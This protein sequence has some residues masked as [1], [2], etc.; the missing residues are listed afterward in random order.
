MTN[1][2]FYFSGTGNSLKVAKSIAEELKNVEIVSMNQIAEVN[3]EKEYETIGFV[4]PVYFGG[5][6]NKVYDFVSNLDL[7]N[8]KN[9]YYYGIATYGGFVGN[10]ISQLN[11]LLQYKH[12]LSLDFGE[13]LKMFA[14]YIVKYKMRD[15]VIETT[16]KSNKD[17]IPILDKIKRKE[18]KKSKKSGILFK[19]FYNKGIKNIKRIDKNYNVNIN[20]TY[21]GICVNL[22]PV[23]NIKINS[24]KH[25][26]NHECEQC[27]ACIQYCPEQALNYKNKTQNRGR[28][29]HP[30]IN[31]EELVKMN[32]IIDK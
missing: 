17:L 12:D 3:L 27:M 23:Q 29:N 6:P 8:N 26:F 21:C 28:Y 32:N 5:L 16:E 18:E 9:S 10:G 14:N 30:D 22:C 7:K 24:N 31:Y 13:K 2:V 20:C 1:I 4:Y 25:E 15:N 19:F 11:E